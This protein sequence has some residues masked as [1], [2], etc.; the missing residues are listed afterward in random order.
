MDL[1]TFAIEAV[2]DFRTVGA[3]VPSSRYLSQAMLGPLSLERARVV[4][5]VGPGTGAMTQRLLHLLPFDAILLAFEINSRFSRHLESNISDPRLVVINASAE[6]LRE[7]VHARGY[8]SVDAV[9]SSLA[10]GL[11]PDRKRRA[12]LGELASLLGEAGVFTQY[13]Y[14]HRLQMKD[15]R[16]R[17]FHLAH[18]LQVYF[19]SVQQKIIWRNLPPAFVFVCRGPLSSGGR[20]ERS[21]H[22]ALLKG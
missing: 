22:H 11:M 12:F 21:H 7:E 10:L 14:F 13:Q 20:L 9:V 4:V 16:I 3:V 18:L 2:S 15:G 19:S 8:E 1:T 6:T 17:K 5:E